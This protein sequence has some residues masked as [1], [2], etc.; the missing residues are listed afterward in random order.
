[1]LTSKS[2]ETKRNEKKL[3]LSFVPSVRNSEISNI[4]DPRLR[5]SFN[6]KTFFGETGQTDYMAAHKKLNMTS[7][8]AYTS[9]TNSPARRPSTKNKVNA[10]K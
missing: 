9:A 6:T 3:N 7:Y 10:F 8:K 2:K 4:L 5:G 1:M